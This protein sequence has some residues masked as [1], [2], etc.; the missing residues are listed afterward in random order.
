ME[1][2]R[3][4]YEYKFAYGN[5]SFCNIN[6]KKILNRFLE[7]GV[8]SDGYVYSILNSEWPAVK[9]HLEHKLDC[10]EEQI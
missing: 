6:F 1:K 7:N 8:I 2:L 4:A 5:L 3:E 10:C 9:M